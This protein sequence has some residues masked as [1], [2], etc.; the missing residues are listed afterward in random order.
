MK[1]LFINGK[2]ILSVS[3]L[4]LSDTVNLQET[5]LCS[6]FTGSFTISIIWNK[7]VFIS[8]FF[9]KS[10]NKSST[11]SFQINFELTYLFVSQVQKSFFLYWY[12][13]KCKCSRYKSNIIS[14]LRFMY[15]ALDFIIIIG[16]RMTVKVPFQYLSQCYGICFNSLL[17]KSSQK[18]LF[19]FQRHKRQLFAC[20][21]SITFR[22]TLLLAAV[23]S[24]VPL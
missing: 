17:N 2:E 7:C 21:F 10:S 1:I 24:D 19:S 23:P 6:N 18:V 4:S 8:F 12:Q 5:N 11:P 15:F 14:L 9:Y 20:S 16:F 22:E 3:C 13:N